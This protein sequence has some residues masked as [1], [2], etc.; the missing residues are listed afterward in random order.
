[1]DG[2]AASTGQIGRFETGWGA[3][4]FLKGNAVVRYD[5]PA[6][7]VEALASALEDVRLV[8]VNAPKVDELYDS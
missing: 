4:L 7:F 8:Y 1:M 3:S 2:C 5:Q 6:A